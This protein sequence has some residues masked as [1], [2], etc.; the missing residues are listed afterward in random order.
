VQLD[1]TTLIFLNVANLLAMSMA[2]PLVMGQN[3]S[4]AARNARASLMING[5]AWLALILAGFWRERWPDWLFSTVAMGLLS[6]SNWLVYRAL[7]QWL[8][9]RPLGRLLL[10]LAL[11]TPLG[12]ALSFGSYPVRV[13]W[14]NLLIAAQ[15]LV[16]ARA[17]LLPAADSKSEGS[18]RFLLFGCVTVM[19]V[20]TALRGILGAWFTELYPYFRAPTPVNITALVAAN[21]TLVLGNIAMLAAWREEAQH[22]LRTLVITDALTGLFNRNGWAEQAGRALSYAQR[23][24]HPL[25]L[26]MVD[27]DHFKR[28]NDT[29]GHE[30]GDAALVFFGSLLRRCQRGGDV[31]AR[32]G[33][34]EFCV[35]LAHADTAAARA[36]D[37]RL[38][39]ELARTAPEALRFG[40]DFSSGHALCRDRHETLESLMA[41]ADAAL[42][43]AKHAGRG[44]LVSAETAAG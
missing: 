21:V 17:A 3:L 41:R 42:Y 12:Y 22:Q 23:H 29:H 5:A 37:Q 32:L 43:G 1:P 11:A 34:E 27:L 33:G 35:L 15:L 30:A 28:I 13:G 2:L 4:P 44:H 40:L 7:N 8:G 20:L 6:L 24:G 18:W 14:A 38:R 36:F 9:P 31:I 10:V 19:A 26:L 25:S 39:N 16:V